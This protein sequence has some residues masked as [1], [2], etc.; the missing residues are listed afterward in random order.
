[1]LNFNYKYKN[2]HQIKKIR[3]VRVRQQR[4]NRITIYYQKYTQC[5]FFLQL[6][7][8]EFEIFFKNNLF[9]C[10]MIKINK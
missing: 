10:L 2:F 9:K 7:G 1:M 3:I 8:M 6:S 4:K 5:I